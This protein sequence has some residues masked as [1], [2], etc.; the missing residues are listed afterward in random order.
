MDPKEAAQPLEQAH[1]RLREA[2]SRASV[3][4]D[5]GIHRRFDALDM[6]LY[7]AE[8]DCRY[9]PDR[10]PE[11]DFY[12]LHVAITDLRRGLGTY[13][14]DLP[15]SFPSKGVRGLRAFIRCLRPASIRVAP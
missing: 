9:H 5:E 7:I 1:R 13:L 2:W 4:R 12:P 6:A 15:I 3:L 11:V 10:A 8:G 14:R